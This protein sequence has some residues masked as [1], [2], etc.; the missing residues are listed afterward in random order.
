MAGQKPVKVY[1]P[2]S[3]SIHEA[4]ASRLS[5]YSSPRQVS[6]FTGTWYL[7]GK[8]LSGTVEDWLFPEGA[9]V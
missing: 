1:D 5:E 2:I 4:L 7:C 8:P 3:S 9:F 6:V